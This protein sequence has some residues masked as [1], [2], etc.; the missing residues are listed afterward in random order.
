VAGLGEDGIGGFG[1]F[2]RR[3]HIAA[4][5]RPGGFGEQGDGGEQT[6][7]PIVV[8]ILDSR[9]L[10][11]GGIKTVRPAQQFTLDHI[12]RDAVD[13]SVDRRTLLGS[14]AQRSAN[15]HHS[16]AK[17]SLGRDRYWIRTDCRQQELN[18]VFRDRFQLDEQFPVFF[19]HGHPQ[20]G[21]LE[22]R[23]CTRLPAAV[24]QI[25]HVGHRRSALVNVRGDTVNSRP[26]SV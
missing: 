25:A 18:D 1:V 9:S 13:L 24:L 2:G 12:G 20:V 19:D 14:V 4:G 11:D 8:P 15:G 21:F 17:V 3:A 26:H 22:T 6:G 10:V 16:V 7:R 23:I 5:Q